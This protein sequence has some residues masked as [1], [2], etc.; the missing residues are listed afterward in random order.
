[1]MLDRDDRLGKYLRNVSN[2]LVSIVAFV[3]SMHVDA[4]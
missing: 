4:L 3:G 1:M 2:I